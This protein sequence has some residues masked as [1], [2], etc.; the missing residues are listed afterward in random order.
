MNM[1]E[2]LLRKGMWP[3][4]EKSWFITRYLNENYGEKLDQCNSNERLRR[5]REAEEK[6]KEYTGHKIKKYTKG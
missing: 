2:R 6:Y 5:S 1:K 3:N 4:W